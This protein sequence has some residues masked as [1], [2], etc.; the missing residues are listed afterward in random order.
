MKTNK[1]I[2]SAIPAV[3][4][5]AVISQAAVAVAGFLTPRDLKESS[6]GSITRQVIESDAVPGQADA[7]SSLPSLE[8]MLGGDSKESYV[9]DRVSCA[10]LDNRLAGTLDFFVYSSRL[11]GLNAVASRERAVSYVSSNRGWMFP[12]DNSVSYVNGLS[13]Y[14]ASELFGSRLGEGASEE[15]KTEIG[16]QLLQAS[17]KT[18]RLE[19]TFTASLESFQNL[20]AQ[21]AR[22]ANL[23]K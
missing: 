1:Y 21:I 5:V 11:T 9:A 8:D 23:A 7:P 22:V 20:D 14:L 6:Q 16:F 2:L 12:A 17:L 15:A 13:E 10:G 19:A 3:V 4:A 18:C